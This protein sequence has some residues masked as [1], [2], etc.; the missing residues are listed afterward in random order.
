MNLQTDITLCAIAGYEKNVVPTWKALN[1]SLHQ[2]PFQNALFL[3]PYNEHYKTSEI[4]GLRVIELPPMDFQSFNKFMMKD[5][6]SYIKTPYVLIVQHD[7]FIIDS[8]KWDDKYFQYDYVGAPWYV[9]PSDNIPVDFDNRVGNGGFS[10]RSKKLLDLC[11]QIIH[12]A[13][14]EKL[15]SM[16]INED[17][18]ICRAM[19]WFFAMNGC[20]FAE[21]EIAAKFSVEHPIPE[22][23]QFNKNNILTYNTFG[24]HGRHNVAAMDL[25]R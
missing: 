8:T 21:P 20:K 12:N 5:F 11:P 16:K 17:V 7:G 18:I 13:V 1:Y 22:N 2:I 3:V 15:A 10:L 14:Y 25:I 19:K 24:F 4:N 6:N 9:N 23:P